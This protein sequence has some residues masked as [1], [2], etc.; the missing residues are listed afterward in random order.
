MNDEKL[1]NEEMKKLN[2]LRQEMEQIESDIRAFKDGKITEDELVSIYGGTMDDGR[3]YINS[4]VRDAIGE[5]HAKREGRVAG[6]PGTRENPIFRNGHAFIYNS[7]NDLIMWSDY[8]GEV[9]ESSSD[10]TNISLRVNTRETFTLRHDMQASEKQ[11]KMLELA[12]KKVVYT[13][14]CPQLSREQLSGLG[15]VRSKGVLV[16]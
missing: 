10:E 6:D 12:R 15:R 8:D 7:R 3:I 14:D 13:D 11:K 9:P 5:M 4:R 16:H 2:E 1:T